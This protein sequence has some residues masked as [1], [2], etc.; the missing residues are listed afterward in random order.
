MNQLRIFAG[1]GILLILLLSGYIFFLHWQQPL[2]SK[3]SEQ[4]IGKTFVQK[5]EHLGQLELVRYKISD[6]MEFTQENHFFTDNKILM[7]IQGEAIACI[8]LQQ[9]TLEDI[10][11][12]GD[13]L[14]LRLPAPQ[15]CHYKLNQQDCKVYDL[16]QWKLFDK[17][18]LVD[19]AYKRAESKV[20]ELALQSD[21]LQV[22]RQNA[23]RLLVPLFEKLSDKHVI[24]QFDMNSPSS[25][26]L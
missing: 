17:S 20:M 21:C 25:L 15:I 19:E 8:D 7:V 3:V 24:L 11:S 16:N 6:V 2:P 9:I 14:W 12:Q 13:S 4:E 10:H 26:A 23:E 1:V 5:V 22:A 18:E